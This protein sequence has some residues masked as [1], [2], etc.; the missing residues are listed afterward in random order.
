MAVGGAVLALRK[1]SFQVPRHWPSLPS[2]LPSFLVSLFLRRTSLSPARTRALSRPPPPPHLILLLRTGGRVVTVSR[3]YVWMRRHQKRSHSRPC[4][5]QCL[6]RRSLID[7]RSFLSTSKEKNQRRERGRE[8]DG[9]PDALSRA[10][11][12]SRVR[13]FSSTPLR[14]S[15]AARERRLNCVYT[16][17][18]KKRR[19]P[20]IK[21]MRNCRAIIARAM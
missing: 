5:L 1:R 3:K 10:V 13:S 8:R 17:R 20:V 2:P 15:M 12:R 7:A 4:R 18:T 9:E 21:T 14:V 6:A 16:T 19:A 11:A